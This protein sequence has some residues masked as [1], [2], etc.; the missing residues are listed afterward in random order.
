MNIYSKIDLHVLKSIA[1][2]SILCVFCSLTS[3]AQQIS[4][5]VTDSQTGDTLL[6]PSASYKGNHVAVS[7]D[8]QGRYRIERHNGW[9]LT[10]SAV[11][12]QSKRILINEKTPSRLDVKLKPDSKQLNEVVI[13]EKRGKYSRKD[14]PAVELM[15]RVIAAKKRTDLHNHDYLQYNKYQ[16]ITLAVNDIGSAELT[17][18][19]FIGKRKWLLD[20]V[21]L[22]PYNQKLILPISVDETVTQ[23]LYR[24][25]PRSERNIV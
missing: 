10:F 1:L 23:Y 19:G 7:G 16:K 11:G 24:R 17:D 25:D 2:A 3:S 18:S 12:Y 20:Q 15:R 14:N 21:E 5:V 22:C 13:K 4:G 9:Y 8:A 6:Y